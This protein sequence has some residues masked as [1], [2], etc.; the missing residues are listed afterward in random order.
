MNGWV[1]PQ[2]GLAL[3]QA[4][5]MSQAA[6]KGLREARQSHPKRAR[7]RRPQASP[8]QALAPPLAQ[9]AALFWGRV[10]QAAVGAVF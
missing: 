8:S 7:L 6:L 9:G 1:L 2:P 5:V 4:R 3:R 10:V